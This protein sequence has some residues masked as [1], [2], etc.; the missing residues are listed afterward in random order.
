MD[1]RCIL[2]NIKI[3]SKFVVQT[4]RENP[5]L[6][7]SISYIMIPF[8]GSLWIYVECVIKLLQL[9]VLLRLGL[10]LL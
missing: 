2:L 7:V 1:L 9:L 5:I 4:D 6:T 10:H 3:S 8:S